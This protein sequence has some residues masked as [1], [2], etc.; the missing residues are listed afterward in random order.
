VAGSTIHEYKIKEGQAGDDRMELQEIKS[1]VARNRAHLGDR[2]K[3]RG[4]TGAAVLEYRRALSE[5]GDS[6]PVMNRLAGA[7]ID[8]GQDEQALDL[9][10]R[11]LSLAPD[12]PTAY[13]RLGQ[14]RLKRREF[15]QAK[16]ALEESIQINPFNP[17][18]HVALADAYARL[19]DSVG[20]EKEK[21]IVNRM[22]R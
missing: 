19:G 21:K 3:T 17:E 13:V 6:V 14:V 18:V 11:I 1:I 4:R 15:E 16:A 20:Y 22:V 12:Y 8:L 9:L 5:T 10:N 2:L 7:L